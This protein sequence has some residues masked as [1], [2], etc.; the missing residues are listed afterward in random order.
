MSFIFVYGTL[1]RGLER[2]HLL[3]DSVFKGLAYCGDVNMYNLDSFPAMSPGE[4]NV[5]G[6][7]YDITQNDILPIVDLVEGYQTGNERGSFYV[8]REV[9]VQLFSTGDWIYAQAYIMLR[10]VDDYP[11]IHHGDYRRYL[12]EQKGEP[13]YY[14]GFGS[15]L[16]PDRL[17]ERIGGWNSTVKGTLPDFRLTFNKKASFDDCLYANIVTGL[18]GKDVPVVGYGVNQ[19][20]IEKLDWQEGVPYH[21]IRTVLPMRTE[22]GEELLGWAFLANPDMVIRGGKVSDQYHQHLVRGYEFHGL[23]KL[24]TFVCKY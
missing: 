14:L 2:N 15:N 17:R 18:E 7:V 20:A 24:E 4:G 19:E 10:D 3:E 9:P 13:C 6:E 16:D 5:V 11:T 22:S 1:L 21:Y 8:R 23:G 12:Y